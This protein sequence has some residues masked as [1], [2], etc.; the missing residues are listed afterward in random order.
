MIDNKLQAHIKSQ[1]YHISKVQEQIGHQRLYKHVTPFLPVDQSGFRA[2]DSTELQLARLV[3]EVSESR[4]KGLSV[5]ACFFDL[6]FRKLSTESGT[7]VSS[8][9]CNT[10]AGLKDT[11]LQWLVNY[12]THRRYACSCRRRLQ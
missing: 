9:S 8:R 7:P 2:N 4:D 3:H 1:G 12:L 5:T 11:A 10:S 6:S